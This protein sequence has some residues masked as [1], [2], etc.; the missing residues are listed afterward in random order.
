MD[1]YRH[2]QLSLLML[3]Q[4]GVWLV[5]NLVA[6]RRRGATRRRCLRMAVAALTMGMF[7]RLTVRVDDDV[8]EAH[9]WPRVVG[10]RVSLAEIETV[11]IVRN[12]WYSGWGLRRIRGGWLVSAW[13]LSAVE[14]RLMSGGVLRIGSDEPQAL[15]AAVE[16]A[17]AERAKAVA[18]A[19]TTDKLGTS[20]PFAV[21]P[22]S[23]LTHLIV[24]AD[25]RESALAPLRRAGV[26]IH[27]AERVGETRR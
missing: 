5:V 27:R 21:A 1:R 25:A 16:G 18:A 12:H 17:L 7:A 24:E 13:G 9:F 4:S 23:R 14:M 2:T 11:A 26:R 22:A 6:M 3:A 15:A 20:A 10:R 19:V 8:V